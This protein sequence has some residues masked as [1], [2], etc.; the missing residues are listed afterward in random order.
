[1]LTHTDVHLLVG[2]L[3]LITSPENVEIELGSKVP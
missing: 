2:M 1:M 3:S